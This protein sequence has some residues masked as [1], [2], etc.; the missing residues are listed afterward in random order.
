MIQFITDIDLLKNYSSLSLYG[1]GSLGVF[2]LKKIKEAFPEAVIEYFI[3][4][5]KKGKLHDVEIRT[6]DNYRSNPSEILLVTSSYWKDIA[7]KIGNSNIDFYVL[8]LLSG[9]SKEKYTEKEIYGINLKFATPNNYLKEVVNNFEII[10]PHTN[11]WIDSFEKNTV[12]Y[13]IG[14]SC[15]IYAFYAAV[16]KNCKVY[17]F[18]PDAQNHSLIEQNVFLNKHLIGGNITALNLGLGDGPGIMPLI[19]QDYVVGSHGKIFQSDSRELQA[20]M[21]AAFVQYTLCDTLDYL[22]S[23]YNMLLPQYI[24]IDVDGFE[25]RVVNGAIGTLLHPGLKELLIESDESQ[26]KNISH[27]LINNGF[28]LKDKYAIN[29]ITGYP[30]SSVHNYLFKRN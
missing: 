19:C 3:D 25:A 2:S 7:K 5:I 21:E 4:D 23:R 14:A 28:I 10:E 11:Q 29:E 8:D 12:F 20:S 9:E 26:M 17:T 24:K 16:A 1:A 18:E 6:F 13:D 22:I 27:I 15:G 30:V